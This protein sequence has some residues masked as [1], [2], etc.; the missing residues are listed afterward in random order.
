MS[1]NA[2]RDLDELAERLEGVRWR[3]VPG[4]SSSTAA[5]FAAQVAAARETIDADAEVEI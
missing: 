3:E 4:V 5:T 2:A 1:P